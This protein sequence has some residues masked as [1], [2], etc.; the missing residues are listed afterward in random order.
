MKIAVI[1]HIRH[2]IAAP[3]KGGM[4]AHTHGLVSRLR[5]RGD[6]V[7]FLASGDS[8]PALAP[9]PIIERHYEA[10]LPWHAHHGTRAF[11]KVQR[12]AFEE[13]W[14]HVRAFAPD[15][16]H[17]N[18]LFPALIDWAR[19][20]A[21]P[22]LT[23]LHVPPFRFLSEA[24]ARAKG[25][26]WLRFSTVSTRQ[27]SAWDA[28]DHPQFSTVPNGIDG[29]RWRSSTRTRNGALWYGRI[30]PNKGTADAAQAARQAGEALDIIG[31]IEDPGYFQETVAPWLGQGV[32]YCG[33]LGGEAL[34]RRVRRARV[35]LVTPCWDEPFGLVAA[36]ALASGVPIAGYDRGA[37]SEVVGDCAVLVAQG[38]IAALA[39]AIVR[40]QSIP[41]GRCLARAHRFSM[42]AMMEGYFRL[43]HSAISGRR[44][45]SRNF[46]RTQAELA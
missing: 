36:E 23:A 15:V 39:T 45:V 9:T 28:L 38:D 40:A 6:K 34:C 35:V 44:G 14:H 33:E 10:D 42:G 13:A 1:S 30:T 46:S 8:D 25:C 3:F 27:L 12:S 2:P 21:M 20:D 37:I 43:Y 41:Q 24:I 32:R 11:D 5:E 31:P 17:N 18:S 4:E 16:V 29:S 7:L 19:E 22:M 26:A